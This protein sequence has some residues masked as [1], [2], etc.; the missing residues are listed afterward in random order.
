MR[1]FSSIF[2]SKKSLYKEVKQKK[3]E[4]CNET[5][6]GFQ[7]EGSCKG[8]YRRFQ[9]DKE[10]PCTSYSHKEEYLHKINKGMTKEEISTLLQTM[11]GIEEDLKEMGWED[12]H[13]N[14]VTIME[15]Q[16]STST[17][18]GANAV[19]E[20]TLA[21]LQSVPKDQQSMIAFPFSII[22]ANLSEDCGNMLLYVPGSSLTS[23]LEQQ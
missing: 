1:L 7:E 23:D 12:T 11:Q 22:A 15:E 18:E 5:L 9:E 16:P 13:T 21:A 8:A 14:T 4:R 2:R 20:R 6:R 19:K 17:V 10:R 3:E